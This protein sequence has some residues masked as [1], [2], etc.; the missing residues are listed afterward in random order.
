M[1][2]AMILTAVDPGGEL[3]NQAQERNWRSRNPLPAGH[4]FGAAIHALPFFPRQSL[5]FS[6]LE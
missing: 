5:S 6:A 3:P 4:D 1:I 2:G